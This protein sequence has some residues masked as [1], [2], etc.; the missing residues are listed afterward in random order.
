MLSFKKGMEV[1]G[2]AFESEVHT[3]ANIKVFTLK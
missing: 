2:N 3:L 1:R